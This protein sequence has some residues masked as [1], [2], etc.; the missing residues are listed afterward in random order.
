M[1]I[2]TSVCDHTSVG[3]IAQDDVGRI[4]LEN[5]NIRVKGDEINSV[6]WFN[7]HGIRKL[8]GP[9]LEPVW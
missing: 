2:E 5:F 9:G 4:L 6:G 1:T 8:N 7:P 3:I